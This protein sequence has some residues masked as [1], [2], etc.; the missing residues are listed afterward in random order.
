VFLVAPKAFGALA[1]GEA[2]S[3]KSGSARPVSVNFDIV[4]NPLVVVRVGES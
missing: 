2:K 1:G 4:V 3:R